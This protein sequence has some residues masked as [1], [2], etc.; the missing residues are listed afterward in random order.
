M[1]SPVSE[2]ADEVNRR[3]V[4]GGLA[5]VSVVFLVALALAL[6]VD[7]PLGRVIMSAV[8]IVSMVRAFLLVRSLRKE[9]H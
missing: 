8:V 5:I 9:R 7:D 4:R 2:S 3:R 6:I 1:I